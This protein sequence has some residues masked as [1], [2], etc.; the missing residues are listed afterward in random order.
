MLFALFTV[1]CGHDIEDRQLEIVV[2]YDGD[3]FEAVASFPDFDAGFS[4][5]DDSCDWSSGNCP[6]EN[7]ESAIIYG[8]SRIASAH[9]TAFDVDY[10]RYF[11]RIKRKAKDPFLGNIYAAPSDIA[12]YITVDVYRSDINTPQS[13]STLV[14][15]VVTFREL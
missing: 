4:G 7:G 3:H 9:L 10:Q 11:V 8:D 14:P 12:E 15:C 2:D 6:R 5:G 1:G 13:C